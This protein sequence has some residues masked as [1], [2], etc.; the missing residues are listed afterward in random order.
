RSKL[1]IAVPIIPMRFM[2][3]P[4]IWMRERLR[5]ERGL[6][7]ILRKLQQGLRLASGNV[8]RLMREREECDSG[9]VVR[10]QYGRHSVTILAPRGNHGHHL[11]IKRREGEDRWT[12]ECAGC[13]YHSS[14]R[15]RSPRRI[16]RTSQDERIGTGEDFCCTES[17]L[18]KNKGPQGC[19]D[20]VRQATYFS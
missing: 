17:A 6:R 5:V 1:I 8:R 10:P 2:G 7:R 3:P 12:I 9:A 19:P 14:E 13:C 11:A 20:Q 15:I 4:N 16:T 18:G